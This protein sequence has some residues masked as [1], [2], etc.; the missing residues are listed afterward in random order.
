MCWTCPDKLPRDER[1]PRSLARENAERSEKTLGEGRD[2]RVLVPGHPLNW[3]AG[4][5]HGIDATAVLAAERDPAKA[6]QH[7]EQR[8]GRRE[9]RSGLQWAHPN[10]GHVAADV[11]SGALLRR[12]NSAWV[13][14]GAH[15][16]WRSPRPH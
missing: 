9:S 7:A 10:G 1:R 8:V 4:C 14:A 3:P 11:R 15:E 2:N 13:V 6:R 12:I 16:Q 5:A